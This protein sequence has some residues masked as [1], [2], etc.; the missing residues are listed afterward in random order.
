MRKATIRSTK[1]FWGRA[2]LDLFR[3]FRDYHRARLHHG[4][5][6]AH[7]PA[8]FPSLLG[9]VLLLIGA[10]SVICAFFAEGTPIG[11][12]ALKGISLVIGSVVLFGFTVR[13]TGLLTALPLI[14][15]MSA[16]GSSRFRW[17][18]RWRWRRD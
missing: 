8:Y 18:R 2:H 11:G 1:D 6:A 4:Q 3:L 17:G 9:A 14:V 12:F 15:V 5:R 10:I 7:G 13:G 16:L